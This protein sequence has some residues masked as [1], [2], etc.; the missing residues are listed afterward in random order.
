MLLSVLELISSLLCL[1]LVLITPLV[2]GE[3]ELQAMCFCKFSNKAALLS[4]S[5]C[6]LS[7]K[8][9]FLEIQWF[10]ACIHPKII[11]LQ[12]YRLI[13]VFPFRTFHKVLFHGLYLT[14]GG[15][16]ITKHNLITF[17]TVS[18]FIF[19]N[20]FW[21]SIVLEPIITFILFSC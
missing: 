3:K 20:N 5:S 13:W 16:I 18:T 2:S 7:K 15:S 11:R 14:Y 1:R 8:F 9:H 12:M 19:D 4:K 10:L 6:D 21:A 17:A